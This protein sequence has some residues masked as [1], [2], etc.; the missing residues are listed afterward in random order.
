MSEIHKKMS[1]YY[2]DL[3]LFFILIYF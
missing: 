3:H 2:R 1:I